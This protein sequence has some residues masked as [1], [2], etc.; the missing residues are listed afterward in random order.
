MR[1]AMSV[2]EFL[3]WEARQ[4]LKHEFDGVG[5]VAMAG[6]TRNHARLQVNITTSMATGSA[7]SPANSSAAT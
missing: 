1:H 5:P 4:E 2:D 3:A 7:A 6:G